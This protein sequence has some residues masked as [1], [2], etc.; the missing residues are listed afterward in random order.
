LDTTEIER[1]V[2]EFAAARGPGD[3]PVLS[4]PELS[5]LAG[6][7]NT[8]WWAEVERRLA[9]AARETPDR[10]GFGPEERLLLDFGVLDLRL[11]PDGERLRPALLKEAVS[12]PKPGVFYFSEWAVR[13]F[14][15]SLLYG[16]MSPPDGDAP[17][18]TQIIRDLRGRLYARLLELFQNLPGFDMKAVDLLLSGRIDET[19]DAMGQKLAKGPDERL[20]EQR[21]QLL[22]IR[23]RLLS[24]ARERAR[25]PDHLALFD[26]LHDLDRQIAEERASV[27]RVLPMAASRTLSADERERFMLEEVRFVKSVLWLGVTG[28]GITRTTSVLTSAAP[29]L[30]KA[31]LDAVHQLV[32]DVDPALPLS[33][34]VLIAPFQGNGFYEWDRDTL[35]LPLV[36]TRSAEH[37]VLAALANY[38]ILL[39]TLQEGGRLKKEYERQFG[40][41]F[42]GGF[43]RDY[44]A[45]VLELGRGF[46]GAL[47]PARYAFFRDLLGPKPANLFAP[48]AWTGVG[49]KEN[50]E[51]LKQCRARASRGEPTYEDSFRLAIAAARGHQLVQAVDHLQ[52]ALRINPVDGRAHLALG[53][54]TARMGTVDSARKSLQ[55]AMAMAPNSLWCVLAAEE[56]QKL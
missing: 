53:F 36:P 48:P 41:D 20:A 25:T 4:N 11:V 31:D 55:T 50:E 40:G 47:D 46:R 10:I 38:R 9:R 17:S 34:S 52:A 7:L 43:V 28:S 2:A 44:S 26:A 19:L 8:L 16:E 45:W 6:E 24:R 56:L 15:Q 32:R 42:H 18:S 22:D 54:L 30:T 13:R 21:R 27:R 12:A 33:S 29:R 39:D 23:S 1:R 51:V 49:P 35:F 5:R 14:R 37:A 3:A